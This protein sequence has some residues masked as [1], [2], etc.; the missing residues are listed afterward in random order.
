[1]QVVGRDF[2]GNYQIA[3]QLETK[4][5]AIPGAVDVHVH[6]IVDYPEVRVNVDRSKAAQLGLTE[7]DVTN[8]LLISLS[9]SGQV[10]PNQWLNPQNGVNYQVAVQTPKNLID[11]FDALMRTP[12]ASVAGGS[13]VR[14]RRRE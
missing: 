10:A 6:Q 12:I 9:G 1:M 2:E 8:S 14:R 4:I 3:K 5:A 11:S 13:S 7:R